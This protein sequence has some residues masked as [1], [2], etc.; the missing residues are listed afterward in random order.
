MMKEYNFTY[1]RI[2][3]EDLIADP[4]KIA[5]KF[6][7]ILELECYREYIDGV[8]KGTFDEANRARKGADWTPEQIRQI[9]RIVKENPRI[10]VMPEYSKFNS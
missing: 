1:I 9:D 6:C 3:L 10:F 8:V 7:S 4:A 5:K 2:Q